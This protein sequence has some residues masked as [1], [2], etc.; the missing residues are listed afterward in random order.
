VEPDAKRPL[1]FLLRRRRLKPVP[2]MA[3]WT[4]G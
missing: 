3:R 2:G 4:A 1:S